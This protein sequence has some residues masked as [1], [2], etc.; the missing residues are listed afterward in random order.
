MTTRSG[1]MGSGD[2]RGSAGRG[3]T[4]GSRGPAAAAAAAM[5]PAAREGA[6]VRERPIAATPTAVMAKLRSSLKAAVE[7]TLTQ[8]EDARHAAIA[9]AIAHIAGFLLA[10]EDAYNFPSIGYS[11]ANTVKW[12]GH[13]V[14]L[15]DD[16]IVAPIK[17]SLLDQISYLIDR[18]PDR[19]EDYLAACTKE[20]SG[21]STTLEAFLP[22]RHNA[23]TGKPSPTGVGNRG[24]DVK[25]RKPREELWTILADHLRNDW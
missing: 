2:R 8:P 22:E 3:G 5:T 12:E 19:L 21:R 11:V 17:D 6:P 15:Y 1:R 9:S 7:G 14:R 23:R 16:F 24:F 20:M 13:P 10:I 25:T 4:A 18:V